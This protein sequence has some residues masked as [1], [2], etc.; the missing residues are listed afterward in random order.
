N[1]NLSSGPTPLVEYTGTGKGTAVALAAGPDGLYF[2]DFYKDLNYSSPIDVGAKIYRISPAPA[3]SADTT[4]PTV[5]VPA[6]RFYASTVNQTSP[7]IPLRVSWSASDGGGVASTQ[8]QRSINGGTWSTITLGSATATS[9]S[10]LTPPSATTTYRFRD[11]ATDTS[12]NVSAWATG[13]TF[14]V[15]AYQETTPSPTLAYTSAWTT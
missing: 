15:Q 6:N 8:L 13:P 7:N 1:G 11:R 5:G 4:P 3:G 14:R 10:F 9:W 2:S 12:S